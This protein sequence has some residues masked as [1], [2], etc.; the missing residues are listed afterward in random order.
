MYVLIL[1]I[2]KNHLLHVI[3]LGLLL[4]ILLQFYITIWYVVC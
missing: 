1:T 2:Y 3:L 4:T